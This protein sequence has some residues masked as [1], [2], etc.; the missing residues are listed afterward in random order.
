[1]RDERR[2]KS[3]ILEKLKNLI[4]IIFIDFLVDLGFLDLLEELENLPLLYLLKREMRISGTFELVLRLLRTSSPLAENKFKSCG[5]QV[6]FHEGKFL[7]REERKK[8]ETETT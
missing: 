2:K 3:R 5:E 1:M 7:E 8:D 4:N 6:H